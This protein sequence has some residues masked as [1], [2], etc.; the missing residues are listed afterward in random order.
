MSQQTTYHP[1]PFHSLIGQYQLDARWQI[2][3]SILSAVLNGERYEQLPRSPN[4]PPPCL[5]TPF[6]VF[7]T[8]TMEM[9]K[10][11]NLPVKILTSKGRFPEMTFY[12]LFCTH[13]KMNCVMAHPFLNV[14]VPILCPSYMRMER[15][16]FLVLPLLLGET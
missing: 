6:C 2:Q 1:F 16:W 4:Q 12:K 11:Y 15:I 13:C 5:K 9:Q 7:Y 3:S 14:R 10:C 8:K